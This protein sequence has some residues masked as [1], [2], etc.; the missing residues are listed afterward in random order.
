MLLVT[1][2]AGSTSS[3]AVCQSTARSF[4]LSCTAPQNPPWGLHLWH[5]HSLKPQNHQALNFPASPA[6]RL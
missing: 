2:S 5:S 3:R 1:T 6:E 4:S